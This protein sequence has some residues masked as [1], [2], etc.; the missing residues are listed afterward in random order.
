MLS[1][2]LEDHLEHDNFVIPYYTDDGM[3]NIHKLD[4]S[5]PKT[6]IT[7]ACD[8]WKLYTHYAAN[9][10]GPTHHSHFGTYDIVTDG[11]FYYARDPVENGEPDPSLPQWLIV[12]GARSDMR[13]EVRPQG[14]ESQ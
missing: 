8:Q 10:P 11:E 1:A 3:G 5:V 12:N 13:L 4:L 6:Q 14:K 9:S 7:T 2:V